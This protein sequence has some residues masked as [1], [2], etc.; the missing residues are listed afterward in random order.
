MRVTTCWGVIS[1][2]CVS[3]EP[4][5]SSRME[6]LGFSCGAEVTTHSG[7]KSRKQ[8]APRIT[9]RRSSSLNVSGRRLRLQ[10]VRLIQTPAAMT[11]TARR[12][13]KAVG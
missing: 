3:M 5:R 1:T 7:W 11:R 4:E 10:A 6:T 13:L 8:M 2:S 12:T 9:R